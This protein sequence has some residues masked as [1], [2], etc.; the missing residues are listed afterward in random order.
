MEINKVLVLVAV[1]LFLVGCGLMLATNYLGEGILVSMA[2][3]IPGVVAA[4]LS[5][6]F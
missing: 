5:K 2:T 1:C 4:D 6:R 3:I